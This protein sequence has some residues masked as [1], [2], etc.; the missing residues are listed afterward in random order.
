MILHTSLE[1]FTMVITPLLQFLQFFLRKSL[2]THWLCRCL[3]HILKT[4]LSHL[5]MALTN[6]PAIC[7]QQFAIWTLLCLLRVNLSR[8]LADPLEFLLVM[9]GIS[10]EMNMLRAIFLLDG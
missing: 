7:K 5:L 8:F 9:L 6:R 3:H 4:K 1:L 10:N 2:T